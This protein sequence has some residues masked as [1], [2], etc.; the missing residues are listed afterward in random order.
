MTN[1]SGLSPDV[2]HSTNMIP[3]PSAHILERFPAG[4][5]RGSWPA[6]EFAA[7]RRTEGINAEVVMN[8]A[9]DTFDVKV[10]TV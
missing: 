5:P 7:A 9:A 2:Q 10:V 3:T 8:L 1:R 6:E 4:A